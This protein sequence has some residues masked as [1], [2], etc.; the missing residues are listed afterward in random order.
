MSSKTNPETITD[1]EEDE[2]IQDWSAIAKL[3]NDNQLIS[4]PK[5]GEKDYEPD[6]TDV[7][8]LLL[9]RAQQAMFQTLEQGAR[10]SVLKAQV[11]AYYD[12]DTHRGMVP[13]PKGNFLQTMGESDTDGVL[14]LEFYEFLY[15]A[16]RGTVTPYWTQS[17]ASDQEEVKDV[18]INIED[19][20][21]LF[22]DQAEMDNFAIYAQLKRL[23][24]IVQQVTPTLSFF[25]P[26]S[27]LNSPTR[28]TSN[29]VGHILSTVSK[30]RISLFNGLIFSQ[31]HL[32][33]KRYTTS[34]QI[35]ESLNKL[36]TCAKVPHTK[37]E[38]YT[39]YSQYFET[40]CNN[41]SDTSVNITF[42][43]WKPNPAFKKKLPELPDFQVATY[44]K[45]STEQTFPTY[46]QLQT[47]FKSLDYK[48]N[49]LAKDSDTTFWDNNTYIN[50]ELR[51]ATLEKLQT[52]PRNKGKVKPQ[53]T[54][55]PKKMKKN[56]NQ[57]PVPPHVEQTRRLKNG[58]RSFLLAI[59]DNGIISF[60]KISEADFGSEDVWYKPTPNQNN[61]S[62]NNNNKRT[63]KP[64]TN[65]ASGGKS[66]Q[67]PASEITT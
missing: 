25:P 29:I 24:F 17:M 45:N 37:N 55:G 21:A 28:S 46:K 15:L 57:R 44:N 65:A 50:G 51:H 41:P 59:M 49:F 56:K 67:S 58:Y 63:S 62:K 16:E 23:G 7:Q 3:A 48:F 9:Y 30:Y 52:N 27:V 13:H 6:G 34:P 8:E 20:Y 10:G 38:I 22:K 18:P 32:Y 1:L 39:D 11:K 61:A 53:N 66:R 35:Y 14:W 47:V 26:V 31:W 42:N 40:K 54:N 64:R 60:A 5:R 2:V 36:I 12:Q 43:V 33:C 4:L 19:M